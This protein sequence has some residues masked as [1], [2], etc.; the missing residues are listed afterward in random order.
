MIESQSYK[1]WVPLTW[2]PR[3]MLL[4]PLGDSKNLFQGDYMALLL[5]TGSNLNTLDKTV[6]PSKFL[7]KVLEKES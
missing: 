7:T 5:Y 1:V 3:R 6:R 4:G 2:K